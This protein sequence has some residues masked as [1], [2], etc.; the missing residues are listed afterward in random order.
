MFELRLSTHPESM[1]VAV[2][3]GEPGAALPSEMRVLEHAVAELVA[4]SIT[5][6][7]ASARA[8]GHEPVIELDVLVTHAER[9]LAAAGT[10]RRSWPTDDTTE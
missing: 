7:L 4:E 2:G 5:E 1:T 10:R 9:I 3:Y 6:R 8:C